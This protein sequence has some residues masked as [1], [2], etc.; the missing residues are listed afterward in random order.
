MVG[1]GEGDVDSA[2]FAGECGFDGLLAGGVVG[3]PDL[4]DVGRADGEGCDFSEAVVAAVDGE[5]QVAQDI[6]GGLEGLAVL[7]GSDGGGVIGLD[8]GAGA[9]GGE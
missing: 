9:A 7:V 5:A 6:D 8:D 1:R 2:L 3:V 4:E